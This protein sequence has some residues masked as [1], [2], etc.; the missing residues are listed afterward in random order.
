[1]LLLDVLITEIAF[2]IVTCFTLMA[3][4]DFS[5]FDVLFPSI[6]LLCL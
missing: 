5:G 6:N 3:V 2:L 1:M 4:V